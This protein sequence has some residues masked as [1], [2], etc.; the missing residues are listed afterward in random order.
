MDV[1][2]RQQDYFLPPVGD[3]GKG[4]LFICELMLDKEENNDGRFEQP[5]Q[6]K[7]VNYVQ[8]SSLVSKAM[9]T[10]VKGWREELQNAYVHERELP[11]KSLEAGSGTRFLINASCSA[12]ASHRSIIKWKDRIFWYTQESCLSPS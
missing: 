2:K 12:P 1:E 7:R 11:P 9:R 5:K 4:L 6:Q 3:P 10:N 8:S